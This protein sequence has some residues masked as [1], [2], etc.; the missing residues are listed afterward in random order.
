M[1]QSPQVPGEE[2]VNAALQAQKPIGLSDQ[3]PWDA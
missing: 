3:D 1:Q 2:G